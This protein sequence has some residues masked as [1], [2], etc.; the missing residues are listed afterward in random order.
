MVEAG[1]RAAGLQ[2]SKQQINRSLVVWLVRA[3][4]GADRS[5]C[6]QM[7]ARHDPTQLHD[8]RIEGGQQRASPAPAAAAAAAPTLL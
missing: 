1:Q 8:V 3:D 7:A 5:S 4:D 2:R 6:G